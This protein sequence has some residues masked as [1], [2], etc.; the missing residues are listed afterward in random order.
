MDERREPVVGEDLRAG[1]FVVPAR[2]LR[3]EFLRSSGPGGQN[4]N[5]VATAV[6]L[7]FDVRATRALPPEVKDRILRLA[8]PGAQTAGVIRI[9][10]RR[11][12]T[13]G[14]NRK[15]AL[16]RLTAIITK[17]AI[18]PKVRRPT[19][20]TAGS[21]E[22]RLEDKKRVSRKKRQRRASPDEA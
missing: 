10:A 22:R 12:R 2:E 9:V 5:K 21:R 15:D 11:F 7:A 18:R 20:P 14:A 8:G 16:A 4:V 3:V 19:R 1:G 17:A 13:Q 6:R